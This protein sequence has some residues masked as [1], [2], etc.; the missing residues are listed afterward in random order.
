MKIE[1]SAAGNRLLTRLPAPVLVRIQRYFRPLKFESGLVLY[2][3]R[4]RIEHSYFPLDGTL[5]A[6]AVMLDGSMIEVA[7]VGNEGAV[8][9]PSFAT[10]D[11]SPNRVFVQVP[12]EG[13]RIETAILER[14]VQH[15][16]AVRRL[17]SNYV[18][19]FQF[20]TSQSVACNG[21]HPLQQRCCRWLLMTHDRVQG[22]T[23]NLTHEFLA[24]MLGVRRS[25]VSEVLQVL[26]DQGWITS[27]RGKVAVVDRTGLEKGSC[28]CYRVVRD[29]YVRLLG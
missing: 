28:E 10:A 27:A 19:A 22:D 11:I 2:E 9:L 1:P 8:G 16:E 24:N 20:Q 3:A 29:E 25:S 21:L 7:T 13:M 12:G 6:V 23:I 15:E 26:Q 18:M 4:S 17:F 5:S 14:E